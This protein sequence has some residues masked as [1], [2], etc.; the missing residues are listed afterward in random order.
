[1]PFYHGDLELNSVGL[2]TKDHVAISVAWP[3]LGGLFARYARTSTA[4]VG[5]DLYVKGGIYAGHY[6][7]TVLLHTFL[8][9]F[10]KGLHHQF[11]YYEL[12]PQLF[13]V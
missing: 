6:G 1:M 8:K 9:L 2:S 13:V 10:F 5:G 12:S 7:T 3:W 11:I 4:N